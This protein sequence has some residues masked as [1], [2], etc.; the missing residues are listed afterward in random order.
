VAESVADHQKPFGAV[1]HSL[2]M[3]FEILREVVPGLHR[4]A[5]LANVANSGARL[6][7]EAAQAAAHT[8]SLNPIT[9]EVR[10]GEDIQRVCRLDREQQ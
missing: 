3:A 2:V 6:E 4:P 8:L 9:L 5:I 10:R 7:F 1:L